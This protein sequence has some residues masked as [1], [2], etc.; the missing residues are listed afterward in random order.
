MSVRSFKLFASKSFIWQRRQANTDQ[1]KIAHKY[2]RAIK[3]PSREPGRGGVRLLFR[4]DQLFQE[5]L[6]GFSVGPFSGDVALGEYYSLKLFCSPY[7]SRGFHSP[8]YYLK[9][10]REIDLRGKLRGKLIIP[11][12]ASKPSEAQI[13]GKEESSNGFVNVV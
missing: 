4:D 5:V 6:V 8:A 3:S 9:T 10:E 13:K 7:L 12:H 1:R 11:I 2:G